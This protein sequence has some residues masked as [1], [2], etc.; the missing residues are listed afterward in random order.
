MKKIALI[1]LFALIPLAGLN[2]AYAMGDVQAAEGVEV[3]AIPVVIETAQEPGMFEKISSA[4]GGHVST[5]SAGQASSTEAVVC[6]ME[7]ECG[8]AIPHR[9]GLF[10]KDAH[11]DRYAGKIE[12]TIKN[13]NPNT[14]RNVKIMLK[15]YNGFTQNIVTISSLDR[16]ESI[17]I[18]ANTDGWEIDEI[19]VVSNEDFDTWTPTSGSHPD[20][21]PTNNLEN[22]VSNLEHRVDVIQNI[23]TEIL[24]Y[25]EY[26]LRGNFVQP[27]VYMG[28]ASTSSQNEMS[29]SAIS[30]IQNYKNQLSQLG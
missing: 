27:E 17:H 21:L 25:V 19:A 3:T 30:Q 29:D 16:G 23:L 12:L 9:Y 15:L 6:N 2:L 24:N 28:Q 5:S 11:Y 18:A 14:E 10:I 20:Y 26:F 7:G 13:D 1:F 22:R 4:F 8:G